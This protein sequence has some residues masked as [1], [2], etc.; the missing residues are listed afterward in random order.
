MRQFRLYQSSSPTF[1][2]F[3]KLF[4]M[5]RL[6]PDGRGTRQDVY[7]CSINPDLFADFL[8]QAELEINAGRPRSAEGSA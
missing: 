1:S 7:R 3:G 8:G 5:H 6:F 4:E 2:K